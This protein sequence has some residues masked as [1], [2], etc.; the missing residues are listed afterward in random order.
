MKART[1]KGV[2][3]SILF[4]MLVLIAGCA[5]ERTN[6][7]DIYGDEYGGSEI[8]VKH[9]N[10]T[11]DEGSV[12][13]IGME[14][15]GYTLQVEFRIYNMGMNDLVLSGN[16][17]IECTGDTDV[18]NVNDPLSTIIS[19]GDST[20]FL[21]EFTPSSNGYKTIT[22]SIKN[23]D[24]DNSEFNFSVRGNGADVPAPDIAVFIDD[25]NFADAPYNNTYDFDDVPTGVGNQ[26]VFTIRNIGLAELSVSS[27]N[28]ISGN[29]GDFN[30]T[31]SPA[32]V[33]VQQSISFTVTFTPSV[34][35]V[36]TCG[37]RIAS[38][39]PDN[40]NYDFTVTGRGVEPEIYVYDGDTGSEIPLGSN[41]NFG[42]LTVGKM[43][44][45]MLTI[46]NDSTTSTD[47]ELTGSPLIS[48]TGS[49]AFDLDIATLITPIHTGNYFYSFI[50]FEPGSPGSV[51]AT[52]NIPN[53]DPNENPYHFTVSGTGVEEF[54]GYT[55][56]DTNGNLTKSSIAASGSNVYI[57]Y[58]DDGTDD[59]KLVKSEDWGTTWDEPI[60]L[61]STGSVGNA[62]SI[63][64]SGGHIY[65]SY[66]DSTNDNLKIAWSANSGLTWNTGTVYSCNEIQDYSTSIAIAGQVLYISCCRLTG[67][68]TADLYMAR[69]T[70][71]TWGAPGAWSINSIYT[72]GNV[73]M[74]NS[75]SV[76]DGSTNS[77]D[78]VYI[79]FS[80]TT[81]G[82]ML[83]LAR[84]SNS[85]STWSYYIIEDH[86]SDNVGYFNSISSY[87]NYVYVS[88]YDATTLTLRFSRSPDNGQTWYTST[89]PSDA[90]VGSIYSEAGYVNLVYMTNTYNLRS[91]Y[92]NNNG[93]SWV[94][95]VN[96]DLDSGDVGF[97]VSVTGGDNGR[98]YVS[99]YDSSTTSL[100]FAKSLNHG[101]S[102]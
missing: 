52:I 77:N 30:I 45:L 74:Y 78:T 100:K 101:S 43:K 35:G 98:V 25:N 54:H 63:C 60:V 17:F 85:G 21:V 3:S 62:C 47:L 82:G 6:P 55:T 81:S 88:Y 38:S 41:Y 42:N 19:S 24:L 36:R 8:V 50:R 11:I 76:I 57:C 27:I 65:I 44:E 10:V 48:M 51:S 23:N 102:W 28:K 67:G 40:Y 69:S 92:S 1:N 5:A 31:F 91:T 68:T 53:N 18:F 56:L 79:S 97:Y 64:V 75:I 89:M 33:G 66:V 80:D 58:Y 46:R 34:K 96:I 70:C 12:Y 73:G 86:A 16:P 20:G 9:G 4:A 7:E 37:M 39:D 94:S 49:S 59:L 2:L 83:R 26:A 61:D 22:I 15:I 93:V 99:Y 29:T 87:S 95:P 71:D 32:T 84:S 90:R 72:S 14:Y 13:D